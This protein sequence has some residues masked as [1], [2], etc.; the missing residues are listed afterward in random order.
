MKMYFINQSMLV[1]I[2]QS[3]LVVIAMDRVNALL[4]DYPI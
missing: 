1:A 3:M 2:N 4:S